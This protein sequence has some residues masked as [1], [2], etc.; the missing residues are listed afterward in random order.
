MPPRG[1]FGTSSG[2]AGGSGLT[3][4]RLS[5]V[6]VFGADSGFAFVTMTAAQTAVSVV[7]TI[8]GLHNVQVTFPSGWNGGNIVVHGFGRDGA[9]LTETFAFTTAGTVA[10]TKA[11]TS[12]TQCTATGG[13]NADK[14]ATIE[15]GQ[16][17]CLANA[18]VSAVIAAYTL[19]GTYS[20]QSSS[21]TAGTVDIGAVAAGSYTVVYEVT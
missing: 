14:T 10:G 6:I 7:T 8:D 5:E 4:I 1:T 18:P 13:G 19:G 3:S 21:L 9:T 20:I 12:V 16:L 17:L 15:I 2:G 11:F